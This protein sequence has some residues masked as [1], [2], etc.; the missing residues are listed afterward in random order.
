MYAAFFARRGL[1]EGSVLDIGGGWGLYRE[2]WQAADGDV[3][4]VHDPGVE[5]FLQGAHELHRECYHRA[6]QY[7]ITFVEGFGEAGSGPYRDDQ[8]STVLIVSTLDHTLDPAAVLAEAR[9]CLRPGGKLLLIQ[10]CESGKSERA[11]KGLRNKAL[12]YL[13]H[14]R[15]FFNAVYK[16]LFYS[17]HHMHHFSEQ[18]LLQMLRE[19]GYRDVGSSRV[20]SETNLIAFAGVC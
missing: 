10:L 20:Q 17:D 8:F 14:P 19:V 9:R 16:R 1:L 6:F 7:P 11:S 12:N 5:R 13:R 15:R 18:Q 3:F 4:I 2:W